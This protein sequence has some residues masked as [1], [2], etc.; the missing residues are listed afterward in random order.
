MAVMRDQFSAWP[1]SVAFKRM[2]R[3]LVRGQQYVPPQQP[4]GQPPPGTQLVEPAVKPEVVST[5]SSRYGSW[6]LTENA[7]GD[8]VARHDS[9]YEETIAALPR[10]E[11]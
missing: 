7:A 6:T 4:I 8:F 2:L 10:E 5:A 9:G 1:E 11:Q 3:T